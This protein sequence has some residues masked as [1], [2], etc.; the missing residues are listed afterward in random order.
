MSQGKQEWGSRLGVILAVAGSAVGLG[1]FLRFPGN[2]A[3][4]GGGA[5]M[6]PYLLAFLLLGIPIAWAEWTMARY[7]GAKGFHSAPGVLGVVGRGKVARYFGIIGVLIPL[8]VYFYYVLIESWCL[9]YCWEYLKGGI[10]VPTGADVNAQVAASSAHFAEFTGAAT[11][12]ALFD[13]SGATA[14]VHETS[15][16]FWIITFAVNFFFLYRGLSKGIEAFCKWAMP[17]MGVAAIIVLVRVLTMDA[18]PQH[19][20][21]T[22]TTGLG[23]MWNPDWEALK[24]PKTWLAAAG[25]IFFSLSVGFGVIINYA[26]YLKRKDDVV[27][28]SVTSNATNELFEVGFG[29][30]IT[31]PAAFLFMGLSISAFQD[32]SFGLGFKTLPVVFANMP[33]GNFMG[34]IWFFMLFL[35]AITSSLSMLQPTLAFLEEALGLNRKVGTFVLLVVGALGNL[36]VLWH[37]EGLRALDIIDFWIGTFL[38]FILAT[39]Q[40]I[41][42][43]WVWGIEKGIAE[44]HRGAQLRIPAIFRFIMKYVSPAYLLVIFVLFIGF[45]VLDRTDDDGNVITGYWSKIW[46]EDNQVER[47]ALGLISLVAIGLIIATAIGEK[48]WRA[49]GLD[50]DGLKPLDPNVK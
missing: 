30:L 35:A 1:N 13:F 29:G 45:N 28:S 8:G 46:A 17:A 4:N 33:G 34:A 22:I 48:R 3:A 50:V 9:G 12:G 39:V 27:L 11:D 15:L 16:I 38:I 47:L 40:I 49:Q 5:F 21:Q 24:N 25:Q 37:S 18:N 41:C 42:F 43:G 19:P 23:Y 14:G 20:D 32:S 26:S 7:G 36:F 44:A 6:V 2:V 10:G 31:I